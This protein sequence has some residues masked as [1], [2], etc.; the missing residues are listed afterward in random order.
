MSPYQGSGVLIRNKFSL[1]I[2]SVKLV[3]VVADGR[4]Q[5]KSTKTR[6][7]FDLEIINSKSNSCRMMIHLDYSS[8]TTDDSVY[9]SWG[10]NQK[11][12]WFSA[13]GYS[14]ET[15]G[16]HKPL[17]KQASRHE[18]RET[19]YQEDFDSDNKTR[20]CFHHHRHELIP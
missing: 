9:M 4:A 7:F 2:F 11:S 3:G 10:C 12:W 8:P 17:P 5:I 6:N 1:G 13:K 18:H 14:V 20:A 19:Q 15:F 16:L